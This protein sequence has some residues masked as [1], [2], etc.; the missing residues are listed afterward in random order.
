MT[1]PDIAQITNMDYLRSLGNRPRVHPNGFIQLNVLPDLRINVWPERL[2]L[3]HPGRVHPIHDHSFDLF[4]VIMVGKLT[5]ITYELR[6]ERW[7]SPTHMLW[8]ARKIDDINTQLV[9]IHSAKG[10][11]RVLKMETFTPGQEYALTRNILHD[12][13][14]HGLTMTL[15][16]ASD[17][18]PVYAPKVA[19]PL[20]VKPMNDFRRDAFPED[21][22]WDTI[23]RALVKYADQR[24]SHSPSV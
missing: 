22:L 15:M 20:A 5:N 13:L 12:S 11:I 10:D 19:V 24:R 21:M 4:S 9:P 16:W 2:P 1:T 17:P 7:A 18:D 8:Q 6:Q 14:P 23:E 3:G